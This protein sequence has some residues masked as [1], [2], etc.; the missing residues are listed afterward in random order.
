MDPPQAA[1]TPKQLPEAMSYSY[2]RKERVMGVKIG[3]FA[4]IDAW[5]PIECLR[6]AIEA[7]RTGFDYIGVEDHLIAMPGGTQCN[8]GWTLMSSALQATGRVP[9]FTVVTAP[10]CAPSGHR[11]PG[12]RHHG[13]DVPGARRDW[14]G[15]CGAHQKI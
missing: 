3:Y 1:H 15:T 4:V 14:L 6:Q 9:F 8:F 2:V 13:G 10:L 11:R 5:T 12:L 7:E